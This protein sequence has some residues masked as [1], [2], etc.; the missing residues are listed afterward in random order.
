MIK[1]F[2]LFSLVIFLAITN[3]TLA[4]DSVSL[5]DMWAR[6]CKKNN[7]SAVY[8]DIKNDSEED[9]IILSA[10]ADIAHMTEI[11]KTVTE[12]GISQMVHIDRLVL[13]AGKTVT[14][15]PKGLHIM[16]MGVKQDLNSG[17][18]FYLELEFKNAG[19]KIYKVNVK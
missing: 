4:C 5:N 18:T 19:S 7:T 3:F 2:K 13:P 15:K 14:F 9:E 12:N 1:S 16:L 6:T 17:D 8:F 10:N 11:H